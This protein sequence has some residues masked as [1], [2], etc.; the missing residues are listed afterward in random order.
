MS[1]VSTAVSGTLEDAG[2]ANA[3]DNFRYD[4]TLGGYTYNLKTTGFTIGTY[5][6]GFVASGDPT[7]HKVEFQVK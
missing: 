5:A 6:I 4:A 1:Q 2:A 3:D 7:T